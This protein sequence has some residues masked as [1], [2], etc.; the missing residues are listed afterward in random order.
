MVNR[1]KGALFKRK[2]GQYFIHLPKTLVEDTMFPITV[3]STIK[4]E[5][6]FKVGDDKVTIRKMKN[7][8]S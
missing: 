1:V 8:R 3:E 5:I 7:E 4:V 6:S 2:D